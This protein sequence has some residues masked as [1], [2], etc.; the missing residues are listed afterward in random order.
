MGDESSQIKFYN[1]RMS[2]NTQTSRAIP[3]VR[4][5]EHSKTDQRTIYE[6]Q[7]HD[8]KLKNQINIVSIDSPIK[9]APIPHSLQRLKKRQKIL[10][11]Y[12]SR[13]SVGRGIIN[14]LFPEAPRKDNVFV[15]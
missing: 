9:N 12:K 8:L 6:K 11:N 7:L 2:L 4:K 3:I 1:K 13:Q 5:S 10:N 14:G 15:T